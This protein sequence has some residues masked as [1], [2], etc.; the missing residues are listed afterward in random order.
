MAS[1]CVRQR[2][3]ARGVRRP[4]RRCQESGR[5]SVERKG[6]GGPWDEA[7]AGVSRGRV[8][9]VR[10]RLSRALR[11]GPQ[12]AVQDP[13]Q[14]RRRARSVRAG[15]GM[16]MPI[17]IRHASC[18]RRLG[19]SGVWIRWPMASSFA[20]LVSA[21]RD[22]WPAAQAG[23]RIHASES[24]EAHPS[25]I[26]RSGYSKR[27]MRCG[28]GRSAFRNA[29]TGDRPRP[30]THP[31]CHVSRDPDTRPSD[32]FQPRAPARPSGGTGLPGRSPGQG[33]GDAGR[34]TAIVDDPGTIAS[35]EA[36]A[37]VM[38]ARTICS[39]S[40]GRRTSSARPVGLRSPCRR[41][42]AR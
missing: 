37:S 4:E 31:D 28:R 21:T 6:A 7:R 17:H 42:T 9:A 35:G 22:S 33:T 5:R 24:A 16:H 41:S 38:P 13:G 15:I 1:G 23:Q 8:A 27:A 2:M 20:P 19:S 26:R 39:G 3:G 10:P 30:R 25:G 36:G 18:G 29:A 32:A 14:I 11:R 12:R 40:S 34:V